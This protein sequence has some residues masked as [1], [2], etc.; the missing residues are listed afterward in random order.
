MRQALHRET[1]N[2]LTGHMIAFRYRPELR[3]DGEEKC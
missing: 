3:F 2:S 1:A